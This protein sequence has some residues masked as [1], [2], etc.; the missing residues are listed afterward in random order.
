MSETLKQNS[1]SVI[2]SP[3]STQWDQLAKVPFNDRAEQIADN[4]ENTEVANDNKNPKASRA[5]QFGL[6]TLNS[7]PGETQESFRPI[8]EM[9]KSEIARE[10]MDLL[11]DLSSNFTSPEGVSSR[12]VGANGSIQ[13]SGYSGDNIFIKDIYKQGGLE[14]DESNDFGEKTLAEFHFE[15][16]DLDRA[17]TLKMA[18]GILFGEQMWRDAGKDYEKAQAALTDAIEEL[19][20]LQE[21]HK[22]KGFFGRLASSHNFHQQA[23]KINAAITQAQEELSERCNYVRLYGF[24]N[25]LC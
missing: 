2:A 9:E 3:E 14:L 13:N 5:E 16:T 7:E 22:A 8:G 20:Q 25:K 17:H 21:E 18:D 4:P 12:V 23:N 1:E 15:N 6:K 11:H 10:Y 19:K 24:C